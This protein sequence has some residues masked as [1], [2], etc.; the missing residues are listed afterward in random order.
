MKLFG[1][2][3]FR[4]ILWAFSSQTLPVHM[5]NRYELGCMPSRGRPGCGGGI[6]YLVIGHRWFQVP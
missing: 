1:Y 3:P 4:F 2:V 6:Y 5:Q